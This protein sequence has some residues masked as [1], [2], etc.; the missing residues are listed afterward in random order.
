MEIGLVFA[1]FSALSFSVGMVIV[2]RASADAGESFSATA[3]SIFIGL[4]FFAIA[5]LISG[6]WN[7]LIHVSVKILGLLAAVGVVHF[8][9]GRLLAYSSFRLIGAN[10]ATP[11]IQASPICTIILSLIFLDEPLTGFIALGALFMLA[12]AYLITRE[13]NSVSG[14]V[15]KKF[16]R[17]EVKGILL[18]LGAA[19]CWGITPVLIKP[20]VTEIG[21]AASGTMIAYF[22]A[23][24]IIA[25][26]MLKNSRFS[27]LKKLPFKKVVLPM[28]IAGVFTAAGQLLAF[29]SLETSP[30]NI[31]SPLMSIQ[32]L[33]VFFLSW[34]INRRL[35]IFSWKVA[36]GMAATL[37]GTVLLFL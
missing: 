8:I 33:F 36:L 35:E 21:S 27:G 29:I 34:L 2:R 30:A 24:I 14:E 26:M 9:A 18:A 25:L 1:L 5:I 23:S 3:L 4:P 28:L 15:K 32:I 12:G 13:K 17:D 37:A 19:V 10:R 6:E 7:A 16:T 11:F 22:T 20:A 31:V